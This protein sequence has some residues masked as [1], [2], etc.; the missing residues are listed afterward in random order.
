MSTA[1]FIVLQEDILGFDAFVNGKALSGESEALDALARGANVKPLMEFFSLDPGSAADLL[2]EFGGAQDALANSL[3]AEQ[4]F[5]AQEGLATVSALLDR[6]QLEP[7]LVRDAVA[8]IRELNEFRDVLTKADQ[9]G[10]GWR[11]AVDF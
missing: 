10:V 11:L 3:P 7:A 9:A 2:E 5:N 6:V 4:W 1:L 8:V